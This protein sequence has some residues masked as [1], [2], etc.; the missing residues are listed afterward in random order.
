M[1]LLVRSVFEQT[2]SLNEARNVVHVL[3]EFAKGLEIVDDYGHETLEQR[4]NPER[5]AIIIEL[6]EFL[7]IIEV[8][9]LYMI[10]KKSLFC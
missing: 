3:A 10:V 1:R 4:G 2:K 7:S 9:L 8:M 5:A 6:E